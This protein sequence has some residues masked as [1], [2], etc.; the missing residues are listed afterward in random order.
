MALV[1]EVTRE[2]RL[3]CTFQ[4][5]IAAWTVPVYDPKSGDFSPV[6]SYVGEAHC[7]TQALYKALRLVD[8]GGS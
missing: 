4:H 5:S 8:L 2:P 1:R 3:S 6:E 7:W